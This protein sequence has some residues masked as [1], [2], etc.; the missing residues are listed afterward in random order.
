MEV[1]DVFFAKNGDAAVRNALEC[2][3]RTINVVLVLC[4]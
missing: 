2:A 1:E 3:Q 4:V